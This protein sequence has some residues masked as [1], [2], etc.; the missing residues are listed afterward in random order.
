MYSTYVDRRDPLRIIHDDIDL[1]GVPD[2]VI[3]NVN[4]IF[5]FLGD[6]VKWEVECD[7]YI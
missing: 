6:F 2:D 5:D 1:V 3:G 4:L 7:T